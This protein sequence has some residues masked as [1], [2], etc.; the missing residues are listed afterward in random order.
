[1]PWTETFGVFV[2]CHLVGDYLFQTEWQAL[3]KYG[4]LGGAGDPRALVA[5]VATYA[6]AFVPAIVWLATEI[7]AAA[8]IGIGALVVL[9][10]LVQDD[11]RLLGRYMLAA[12]RVDPREHP[13]L[14][15]AV[16]QSMH[17]VALFLVAL[18]AAG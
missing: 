10:H 3:N 2:V 17:A 18:A 8:A 13:G 15:V 12:K 14:T 11:G 1:M 4:A 6:L 7:G 9:P 5:H 16:D